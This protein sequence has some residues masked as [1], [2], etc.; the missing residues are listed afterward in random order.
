MLVQLLRAHR[1]KQLEERLKAGPAWQG[2]EWNLVFCAES[3]RPFSG[4][5]LTHKFQALLVSLGLPRQRFHDLRHAAATFMLAQGVDLRVVMEVLGHSQIAVTA[6]TYAH[7]RIEATRLAAERVEALWRND[8]E[9]RSSDRSS[10]P[11]R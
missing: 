10:K 7:V 3:G 2:D 8:A 11:W 1:A 4:F 9:D 6:N 5:H